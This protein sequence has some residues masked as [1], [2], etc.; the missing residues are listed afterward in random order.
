MGRP[1]IKDKKIKLSIT[2]NN[3]L[4]IKLNE[5]YPNKSKY[6]EDLIQKDF[7]KNNILEYKLL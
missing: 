7:I 1:K 3:E 6:I 2:I 5:L 4:G